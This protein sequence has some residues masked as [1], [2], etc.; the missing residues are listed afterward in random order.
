MNDKRNKKQ[1]R[2]KSLLFVIEDV[3]KLLRTEAKKAE[4]RLP[5]A[6]GTSTSGPFTNS[7]GQIAKLLRTQTHAVRAR[8]ERTWTHMKKEI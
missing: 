6:A 5:D 8:Q 4:R 1:E 3:A 7:I 2:E